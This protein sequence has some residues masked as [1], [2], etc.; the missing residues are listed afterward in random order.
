MQIKG[1]K[2]IDASPAQCYR[3]L[4]DPGTLVKTMP[5]L[6]SM[7]ERED[8]RYQAELEMGVAAIRGRYAGV[9][10]I[11]DTVPNQSYRLVM[12]GQGPGGFVNVNMQVRFDEHPSGCDVTYDGEARVGGTVAGVGQRMLSGVASF[13]VNQFF[14]NVAREV[15]SL[16]GD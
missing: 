15:K 3:A 12:E 5:G 7:S 9:M 8:G 16:P 10:T 13:I 2:L 11:E 1:H 4:T 14:N 6:K